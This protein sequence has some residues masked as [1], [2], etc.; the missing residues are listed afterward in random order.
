MLKDF[1]GK[2][3]NEIVDAADDIYNNMEP[4]T[5]SLAKTNAINNAS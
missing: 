2:W 4:P 5:A 1:G 3:F